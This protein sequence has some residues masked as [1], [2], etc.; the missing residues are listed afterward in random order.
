MP[1]ANRHFAI[2]LSTTKQVAECPL[3]DLADVNQI[4]SYTDSK[5]GRFLRTG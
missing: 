1:A 3:V 4:R 5:L 2:R